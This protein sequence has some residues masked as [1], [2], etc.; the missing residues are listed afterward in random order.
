MV[1]FYRDVL[2]FDTQWNGEEPNVEMTLGGMRLIMFPRK[3]LELMISKKLQYPQGC[4]GTM[5]L[6]LTSILLPMC[7]RNTSGL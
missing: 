3:D 4:K 1:A 6:P 5:E 2:G 7:I